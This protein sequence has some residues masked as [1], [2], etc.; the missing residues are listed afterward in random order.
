MS[1]LWTDYITPAEL[2]GYARE[3]LADY[4]AAKGTLA[5]WLPNR[6][7]AD[8]VARFVA[9]QTGLLDARRRPIRGLPNRLTTGSKDE[10]AAALGDQADG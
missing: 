1:T 5:H 8:I 10:L 6:E 3:S 2:T 7:V 9:G 4:E